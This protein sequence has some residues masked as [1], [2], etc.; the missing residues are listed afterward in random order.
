VNPRSHIYYCPGS[1]N[2]G[3]AGR[4]K[5]FLGEAEAKAAGDHPD[6][7]KVCS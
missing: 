2:Y 3:K 1:K 4:G 5:Y 7:G 6:H